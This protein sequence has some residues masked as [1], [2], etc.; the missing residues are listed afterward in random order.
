MSCHNSD[1]RVKHLRIAKQVLQYLKRTIT[2]GIE[3]G[4]DPAGYRSGSGRKY[5]E[6][7]VV[8]YADS[9]Y[10]GDINDRKLIT[11][12][13]FFLEK[14]IVT[15]CSKRQRIVSIS[16]SKAEYVGMSHGA[17]EGIWIQRL[18]N[19]LLPKQA[20]RKMEMLGDNE[21]SLML[22]RNL[23][24]QNCTKHIDVMH[25]HLQGLVEDGELG[26]EWISSLLM[27]ADSLT[28]ALPTGLFKKHRDK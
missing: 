22:T 17:K 6:H 25:H 13:R 8:R 26:I 15:W 2:F 19:K 20:I 1:P 9:S 23:A 3:W 4:R 10:T 18:L 24:S 28:K 11:R 21:M 14:D 7:G 27:L 16:T 12:Y 5:S